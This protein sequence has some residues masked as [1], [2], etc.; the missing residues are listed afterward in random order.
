LHCEHKK[1]RT[2]QNAKFICNISLQNLRNGF[3]DRSSKL[4]PQKE[5]PQVQIDV[6]IPQET[7]DFN[8]ENCNFFKDWVWDV[9]KWHFL[10]KASSDQSKQST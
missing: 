2:P 4:T 5:N 9:V 3:A 6:K 1:Y 10:I 7:I 8:F